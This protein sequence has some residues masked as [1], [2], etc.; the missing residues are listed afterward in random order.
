MMIKI[1]GLCVF[2]GR[3]GGLVWRRGRYFIKRWR[4][5]ILYGINKIVE[6]GG[7]KGGNRSVGEEEENK[8]VL[9]D[10]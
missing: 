2:G 5:G 4:F 1:I 10:F 3:W 9:E 7:Y 6:I 8:E